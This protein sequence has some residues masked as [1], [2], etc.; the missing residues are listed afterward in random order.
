MQLGIHFMN[1]TLPGGSP[2]IAPI[3]AKTA[4]TAEDIGCAWFTLMDHYFQMEHFATSEDPMLEGY[5]ALGFVAGRTERM[6]LGL[7]VTG[8]T[9]RHPG[10]L[11]KIVTT[12]DVLSGGR[13]MLGIGA[14]WYEREHLG[15]G[16]PYP[17]LKERFERLEETLRICRQ[18]WSEDDGPFEGTHYRLAETLNHPVPI[19]QPGP[20][21]LIGG[22]GE[23]KTLRLV[24]QYGDA[25]NLF[26]TGADD[27]AHK[28]DVLKRHCDELGRDYAAITRTITGG[29]DPIGDPDGFVRAMEQYAAL[30]IDHVQLAPAGPDPE[31]YV[32]RLGEGVI[33]RVAALG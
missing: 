1:F 20:P 3:L 31:A 24:A 29:G 16:V 6:R 12:L 21:I 11:A 7:L 26:G 25:C 9:Y 28:L 23:R 13:A 15:L 18:M 4:R 32:A 27:V 8:V 30:G 19:Q 10:L 33:E 5:T 2:G 22:G 17:P 14:A